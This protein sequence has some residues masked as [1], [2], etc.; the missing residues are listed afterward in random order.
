LP[1]LS[2]AQ[3][4]KLLLLSL[5]P[6]ARNNKPLSYKKIGQ[7]LSLPNVEALESLVTNAIYL[8]L[9]DGAL[10]PSYQIVHIDSVAPL[11][12]LQP[13]SVPIL[14]Q[15]LEG[16]SAQCAAMLQDI[17]KEI[18]LINDKAKA[19][20]QRHMRI[21]KIIDKKMEQPEEPKTKRLLEE[22]GEGEVEGADDMDVD[23]DISRNSRSKR[24]FFSGSSGRRLGS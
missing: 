23:P 20:T 8:E 3:H 10:D 5:L 18:H 6:L 14:T 12:D 7:T 11:R 24:S 19:K 13:G 15:T 22:G 2:P 1:K 21:Q 17:Q 16:W 4:Q 9:I